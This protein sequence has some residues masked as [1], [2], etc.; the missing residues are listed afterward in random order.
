MKD[1]WIAQLVAS[2]TTPAAAALAYCSSS[3]Q[4]RLRF[5][6]AAISLYILET[7]VMFATNHPPPQYQKKIV[8]ITRTIYCTSLAWPHYL[9]CFVIMYSTVLVSIIYIRR[10][11]SSSVDVINVQIIA[12]SNKAV[13]AHTLRE[14]T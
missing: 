11:I 5:V 6:T 9:R 14:L 13:S 10:C 1:S 12:V 4:A 7:A 8:V 2:C 3:R